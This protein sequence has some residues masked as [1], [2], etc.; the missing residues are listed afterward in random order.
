[1]FK[2]KAAEDFK[3]ATHSVVAS[4]VSTPTLPSPLANHTLSAR[5]QNENL[6]LSVDGIGTETV[7]VAWIID[8]KAEVSV[9][10]TV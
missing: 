5:V 4:F 1:L 10:P 6:I 8:T 7:R 9:G 3:S 2:K